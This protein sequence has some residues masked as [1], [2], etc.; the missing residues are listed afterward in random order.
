[1]TQEEMETLGRQWRRAKKMEQTAN[2]MRRA[3]EDTLAGNF[4][5]NEK[6]KRVAIESSQ[7]FFDV[8]I[9]ETIAID[10]DMLQDA[11]SVAGIDD[12]LS[13]FFRW[14]P[15]LKKSE[16]KT[17][18]ADVKAALACAMTTKRARPTFKIE[19]K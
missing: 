8:T 4:E 5:I 6:E 9:D 11:A 1:M 13:M 19:R 12:C 10:A 2:K 16:W 14:K 15:E 18:S 3:I 7:Y 17:A